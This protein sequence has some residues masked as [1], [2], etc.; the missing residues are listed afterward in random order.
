MGRDKKDKGGGLGSYKTKEALKEE[1]VELT[2]QIRETDRRY[3]DIY[4][5]VQELSATYA[6][7]KDHFALSR[8]GDLKD[9]IKSCVT[10][11]TLQNVAKY[12]VLRQ[13]EKSHADKGKVTGML[14]AAKQFTAGAGDHEANDEVSQLHKAELVK[15]IEEK[16]KK[17]EKL[18]KKFLRLHNRLEKLKRDYEESKRY[19][20]TKRYMLLKEMIKPIIR[21][22]VLKPE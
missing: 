22:D 14:Q 11:E 21:D 7:C 1:D 9:M 13:A 19:I 15:D 2:R 10:D 16:K 20:P 8:Y 6:Q 5:N 3:R 4:R 17:K 12:S 18:E